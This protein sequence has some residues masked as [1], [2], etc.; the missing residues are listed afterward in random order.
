MNELI[1]ELAQKADYTIV[2]SPIWQYQ[3]NKF[4]KLIVF[5]CVQATNDLYGYSGVGVDGNPYCTASWNAALEAAK[6]LI[7]KRL[8]ENTEI[9]ETMI[10]ENAEQ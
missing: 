8:V 3:L 2:N 7:S 6:E 4:I 1:R 9:A 5:E 10:A